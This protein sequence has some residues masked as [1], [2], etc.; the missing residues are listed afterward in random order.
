M[1]SDG[2]HREDIMIFLF[3]ALGVLG[4]AWASAHA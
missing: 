2:M 3:Y 4:M 1:V